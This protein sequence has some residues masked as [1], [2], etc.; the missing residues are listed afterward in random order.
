MVLVE[1]IA[2]LVFLSVIIAGVVVA[3][4]IVPRQLARLRFSRSLEGRIA[5]KQQQ[6]DSQDAYLAEVSA[7][8]SDPEIPD[9]RRQ[10][11]ST[12]HELAS[13]KR[14]QLTLELE[15]LKQEQD[16]Q[17]FEQRMDRRQR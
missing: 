16:T 15:A 7:E 1:A 9:S 17:E 11:L 3:A 14:V 5:R 2:A 8:I 12:Y 6:L 10:H 13:K 4:V